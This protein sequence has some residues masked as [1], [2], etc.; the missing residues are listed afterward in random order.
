MLCGPQKLPAL[1]DPVTVRV[2]GSRCTVASSLPV[3]DSDVRNSRPA[4]L[5]AGNVNRPE[6]VRGVAVSSAPA[7]LS[8]RTE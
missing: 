7:P 2:A 6:P 8:S 3:S 1:T 5:S 4:G